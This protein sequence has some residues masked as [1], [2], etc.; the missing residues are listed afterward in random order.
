MPDGCLT[1]AL[2][3]DRFAQVRYPYDIIQMYPDPL[4]AVKAKVGHHNDC[5][6]A[7]DM[8][9]GTYERLD[10]NTIL[11][12]QAYLTVLTRYTPMSGETCAVYP[13]RSNCEVTLKEMALLHFSAINEGYHKGVIRG[14]EEEGCLPEIENRLGYRLQLVSADFNEKIG[15]D[16]IFELKVKFQNTGFS[17]IINPRPVF[18]VM[19]QGGKITPFKVELDPRLWLPGESTFTLKLQL[20]ADV[21]GQAKLALWLPDAAEALQ[22]DSSFSVQ[23]ANANVWDEPSGLN[24]LGEVTLEGKRQAAEFKVLALEHTEPVLPPYTPVED[25]IPTP[26]EAAPEETVPAITELQ[27]S[28]K[29]GDAGFSFAYNGKTADY[30]GF[31]LFIDTDN[32]PDT[33]YRIGGIG[34]EIMLE[35]DVEYLYTGTGEDWTWEE[36]TNGSKYENFAGIASWTYPADKLGTESKITIAGQLV[37]LN[38]DSAAISEPVE[39][40]IK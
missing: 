40:V 20:P 7:S 3:A 22:K 31:Q 9:T 6:V 28:V 35:N 15:K 23:F 32:K 39:V 29:E 10:H 34:A 24:F 4:D 25:P 30:N 16:G 38:W 33:V 19:E 27:G 14:W 5:F 37:N 13:P 21:E 12:D 11:S 18:I 26:G 1:A 17:A 36:K 8:D 2:P